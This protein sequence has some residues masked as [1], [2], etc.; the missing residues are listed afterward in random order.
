[1]FLQARADPGEPAHAGDHRTVE[2]KVCKS[3]NALVG[4]L[5]RS[6]PASDPVGLPFALEP[7]PITPQRQEQ[8]SPQTFSKATEKTSLALLTNQVICRAE[9][10]SLHHTRGMQASVLD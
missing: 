5:V 9:A 7:Q 6:A 8:T 3:A 2:S 1:M 10:Q 4:S